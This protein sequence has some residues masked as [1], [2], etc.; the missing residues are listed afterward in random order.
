MS[1]FPVAHRLLLKPW[2][3]DKALAR[4]AE[5]L[6]RSPGPALLFYRHTVAGIFAQEK[7]WCLLRFEAAPHIPQGFRLVDAACSLCTLRRGNGD[8]CSHLAVLTSRVLVA[9][10]GR[11]LPAPMSYGASR[12]AA[13]AKFLGQHG[14]QAAMTLI[15]G[16]LQMENEAFCL[17]G[18]VAAEELAVAMNLFPHTV[19]PLAIDSAPL[20]ATMVQEVWQRLKTLACTESEAALN[21]RGQQS[22]GQRL[23]GSLWTFIAQ[24]CHRQAPTPDWRLSRRDD[25]S[26][27]LTAHDQG[28]RILVTLTPSRNLLIDLLQLTD[29]LH[30]IEVTGRARAYSRIF[31]AAAS[32]DLL[33][34]PWLELADGTRHQRQ[35]LDD[36]CFGRYYSLHGRL[37]FPVA[38]QE[39]DFVDQEESRLP[40]FAAVRPAVREQRCIPAVEVPA[41]VKRHHLA[42]LHGGHDL[43]PSLVNFTVA[44]LPDRLEIVD[45]RED[46]QWCLL[47]AR[48]G[49]GSNRVEVADVIRLRRAGA[50]HVV[51]RDSWL[52]VNDTPLGW[53]HALG[54]ERLDSVHSPLVLDGG[55]P[56]APSYLRLTRREMM[57]LTALVPEVVYP[58]R[59]EVRSIL[60]RRLASGETAELAVN[61][62][63]P[64]LRP[65][66]R[67]GLAWLHHLHA[68]GVGGMLCDDMGLGKTHQA[69]ALLAQLAMTP[70]GG[71]A[72]VVCPASVLPHW[73]EKAATFYPALPVRVYYGLGRDHEELDLPGVIIT[74]Y[75]IL[76]QDKELISAR[77]F[78]ALILDEIQTLKNKQTA[79]YQAA[80]QVRARVVYGLTGTP[81]ENSLADLKSICDLCVPGLLGADT[82]FQRVYAAPIAEGGQ[83]ERV[84]ALRRVL[85]PF[86]LRRMKGQVLTELPEVIEDVRSCPLSDDQIAL[87]RRVI[88]GD[89]HEL[90]SSLTDAP[91]DAVIPYMRFLAVVQEL[92]QICNH[93]CQLLGSTNYHNYRSGKW[94][95]FVEILGECLDAGLKVVVFS[96]Y[97]KMLDV[98]DA[99]L[100]AEAIPHAGIR[101]SMTPT[102]RRRMIERFNQDPATRVFCASL[103]AGGTGIDLTAA[104]VVIHYDRWWNSAREEQATA[105]VHRLGQQQVVQVFKFI[106][107]G[108][109]EAKIHRLIHRKKELA[110]DIVQADD[111][112]FV[113]RLC[114][115]DLVELLQWGE[116]AVERR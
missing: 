80:E 98:V 30:L 88:D 16:G 9:D 116:P 5:W 33:I 114:R 76:R 101:G 115:E 62:M 27:S 20:P 59:E 48:Y 53:L 71:R 15:P 73:Q 79:T 85:S 55:E 7:G 87:Y 41:F 111:D 65:Y 107:Q 10:A 13:M 99:Y 46:G 112:S 96:Q 91:D 32:N 78:Q 89:G 72:L 113:K 90:L 1:S 12:W 54:P 64:H 92:K 38:E 11:L 45:Y 26:F 56:G 103:L 37:F 24:V 39:D 14:D 63:P 83:Q 18:A 57:S 61:E 31:F 60:R 52:Q 70:G 86:M 110:A 77:E 40:L 105:R 42:M 47:D 94:D 104:Q 3:S 95:L 93:P 97:T 29:L 66:Q 28:G 36:S 4:A 21:S 102:T 100:Q 49:F 50:Q 2:F 8:L 43:D 75:G 23:A 68:N 19:R 81:I 25:G 74:T 82:V 108:T 17:S 58:A 109:L 6:A 34:E 69:L 51:G 84:Q 106:S 67:Q 22:Q 35:T 44:D